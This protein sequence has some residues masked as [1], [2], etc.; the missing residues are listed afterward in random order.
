MEELVVLLLGLAVIP[1][2]GYVSLFVSQS[3]RERDD[4][5]PEE[6]IKKKRG[7]K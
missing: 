1:V 3:D 2:I 4:R 7:D 5:E 6:W